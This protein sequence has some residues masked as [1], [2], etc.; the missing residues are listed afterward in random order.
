MAKGDY[1]RYIET[2]RRYR[3]QHRDVRNAAAREWR[4]N[5]PNI[6][7]RDREFNLHRYGI[8]ELDY[9]R[10]LVKQEGRCA[11]CRTDNP[12]NRKGASNWHVDHDH[13]TNEVRGLLCNRCNRAI[14]Q[15]EDNP[16][17]LLKAAAYL[18]RA[19]AEQASSTA[20]LPQ[21]EVTNG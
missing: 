2:H 9:S 11:I 12:A 13:V 15:F 21:S 6:K 16:D 18:E 5:H 10:M 4:K 3:E 7:E 14:G 20:S 1:R 19:G 17:L 8:T